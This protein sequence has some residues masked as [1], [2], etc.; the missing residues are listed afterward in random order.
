M[1][2]YHTT[3]SRRDFMKGLG[4]AGVGIGGAALIAPSFNDLDEVISQGMSYQRPWWAKTQDKSTTEVDWAQ[5]K[6]FSEGN[7][8]G[9]GSEYLLTYLSKEEQDARRAQLD[10]SE[11][12]YRAEGKP[13]YSLRDYAFSGNANRGVESN[14]FIGPNAS[15]FEKLG[16]TSKWNT[17]PE[18]H[19]AMLRTFARFSGAM[20]IGFTELHEDTTMKF[21]YEYGPNMRQKY[22]FA[23]VDQPSETTS[24]QVYPRK[25]KWV[26]T[27][28]N[29]ESQALWKMNPTALM[30]QIRYGRAQ[31][32]QARVQGFVKS[33]GY[34]C[35]S[36]GGNGTGIAPAFADASG[37]GELGRHNRFI[38][39][40]YGCTVGIF[41]YVTDM[42][43]P[44]EK[45]IDAGFQ[46]FCKTCMK[47]A[48]VCGEGAISYEKD[49]YWEVKGE[50]N[51]PGKK[52]WF[53][54]TRKCRAFKML[55]DSCADGSCLA[56]CTFTK[57]DK[58][59]IHDIVKATSSVTPLFNGF[60]KTM[61]DFMGYGMMDPADFWTT[62]LPV[63]GVPGDAGMTHYK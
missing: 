61:D 36:E 5:M 16:F 3:V 48:E 27:V 13:G 47:C 12:A 50:W 32:L 56:I 51:N 19:A 26:I 63:Y 15:S 6:K 54:D 53:E 10:A 23:D 46:R 52:A 4:L 41:R 1:S 30:T 34:H 35:L 62:P 21:M 59:S 39:T 2:K 20:S 11:A 40:E 43:L 7:A 55:P 38:T 18:E 45:P 49:P 17:T 31:N 25:C 28:V 9:R 58:A 29:Q 33:L 57:F 37:L 8:R 14:T 22:T 44:D 60:F 24:E 42:P